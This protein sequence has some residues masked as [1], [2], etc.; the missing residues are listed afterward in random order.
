MFALEKL[1][2]PADL[3]DHRAGSG[4]C[5]EIKPSLIQRHAKQSGIQQ[6]DVGEQGHWRVLPGRQQHRCE[7]TAEHA[8][9]RDHLRLQA[10]CQ[11]EGG[12]CDQRH[13]DERRNRPEELEMVNRAAGK[14]D[15]VEDQN[16]RGAK[17]VSGDRVVLPAH[18]HAPGDQTD[19]NQETERDPDFRR[20]EIVFE[21]VF[22][23]IGH[24]QEQREAADPG[25]QL[26]PHELLP[27]Q[28]ALQVRETE[29]RLTFRNR[30]EGR[31]ACYRRSV[32]RWRCRQN[33]SNL[34]NRGG[35][36]LRRCGLLRASPRPLLAGFTQRGCEWGAW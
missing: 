15:G 30:F 10:H 1:G 11:Q 27:I 2:R 20:D 32:Y 25:E 24:A 23:E 35:R 33:G 31:R 13:Q 17:R 3:H 18:H 21:R 8:Q 22:Y 4:E 16:T 12:R 26:R 28:T 14:R 9:E 34:G 7:E 29:R 6:R 19:S 5:A 36:E